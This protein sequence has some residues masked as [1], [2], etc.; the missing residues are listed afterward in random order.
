MRRFTP[1]AGLLLFAPVLAS[2][3]GLMPSAEDKAASVA[4]DRA[5]RMAFVLRTSTS[6]ERAEDL[7]RRAS[8]LNNA[9]VMKVT[10][11]STR[12]RGGVQIIVRVEGR[13]STFDNQDIV[14]KRCFEIGFDHRTDDQGAPPQVECPAGAPLKFGPWPKGA[15]LP[16]E[17]RL[18]KA[19][20]AVPKGGR[21]DEAKI[22]AAVAGMRLDP[23][24]TADYLTVGDTVGVSLT[25]APLYTN[26]ALDCVLVRVAPGKTSVFVPSRIQRMP[27]EGGCGPANAVNPLP[28]PH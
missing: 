10:G 6:L 2:G 21:A 18:R 3:C 15:A 5:G 20:P 28:P 25:A 11:T 12:D 23:R 1:L 22:R 8:E 16:S 24:I 7:G 14:V 26:T 9:E 19:V 17:A 13:S 4:R 27:G